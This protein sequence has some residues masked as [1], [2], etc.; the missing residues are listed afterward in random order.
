MK[1]FRSKRD[2][3]LDQAISGLRG[4]VPDAKTLSA[5]AE[6]VWQSLQTSRGDEAAASTL[7]VIHGCTDIRALLP[8]F[9]K[10]DLTAAR[11]LIVEDHLRECVACRSYVLGR[12]ME[13]GAAATW[14]MEL[15][16]RS[17]QWSLTRLAFAGAVLAVLLSMVWAGRYWYFGELPGSRA[18]V[19][20]LVGQ[21]YRVSADGVRPL[22]QGDA[23]GPGEVIRTA[24]GSHAS[25]KLFD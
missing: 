5:S 17:F 10:K 6:R 12:G 23:V 18:Q 4:D 24:A 8:S 9:Y 16:S 2:S 19:V 22:A 14:R 15:A 3:I 11:A 7:Q 20:S 25:M 1:F 21:A 13:G